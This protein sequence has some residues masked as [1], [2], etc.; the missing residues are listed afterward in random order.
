ME[1]HHINRVNFIVVFVEDFYCTRGV[2]NM[3]PQGKVH[4]C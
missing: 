1:G 3:S 2:G 4:N